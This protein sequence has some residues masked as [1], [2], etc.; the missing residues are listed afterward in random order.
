MVNNIAAK[1]VAKV[2]AKISRV[3]G[4]ALD[5]METIVST[6][7]KKIEA[8]VSPIRDSI[9]K[10][11]PVLIGLA[12]TFGITATAVG[13]EQILLQYSALKNNPWIIFG[14]GI[15]TLILTGTLYKKLG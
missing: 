13:M 1:Q 12:V 3:A 2:E 6:T 7:E 10:R 11:F 15:G 9:F 5:G 8:T 14:L 4:G